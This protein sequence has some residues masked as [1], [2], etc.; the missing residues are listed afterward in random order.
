MGLWKELWMSRA[1]VEILRTTERTRKKLMSEKTMEGLSV[2]MVFAQVGVEFT[3][4]ASPMGPLGALQVTLTAPAG[5]PPATLVLGVPV[6]R[7][8]AAALREALS[9]RTARP[10]SRPEGLQ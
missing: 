1:L 3:E 9:L 7:Q 8:L 6:A 5:Q 4:I 2:E 10:P